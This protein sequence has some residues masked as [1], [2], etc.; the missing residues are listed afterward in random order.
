M[1]QDRDSESP[2]PEKR[3]R[4]FSLKLTKRHISLRALQ[5]HNGLP[6]STPGHIHTKRICLQN[7][8]TCK[9]NI[10]GKMTWKMPAIEDGNVDKAVNC[11]DYWKCS[12]VLYCAVL[13]TLNR[14][15]TMFPKDWDVHNFSSARVHHILRLPSILFQ[16]TRCDLPRFRLEGGTQ[17]ARCETNAEGS[18]P[19]PEGGGRMH[20]LLRVACHLNKLNQI[21]HAFLNILMF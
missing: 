5:K 21:S 7:N 2:P 8:M 4:R 17:P 16:Q 9:V 13:P 15:K 19:W 11:Q 18:Y 1:L 20:V 14:R 6:P 10:M 3:C 12:L